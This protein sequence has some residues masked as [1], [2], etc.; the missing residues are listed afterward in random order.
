MSKN[1]RCDAIASVHETMEALHKTGAIDKQ[2]MWRFDEACLIAG[3]PLTRERIKELRR[4]QTRR[5][6]NALRSGVEAPR[7]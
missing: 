6:E 1:Y 4:E 7:S 5:R 3:H 2:T